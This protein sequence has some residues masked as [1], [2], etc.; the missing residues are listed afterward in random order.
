MTLPHIIIT[1]KN[2]VIM[3]KFI[4]L[5]ALIIAA[6]LHLNADDAEKYHQFASEVRNEVW[7]MD[8]PEFKVTDIPE[9]YRNESAVIIAAYRGINAKKKSGIAFN[10][11]MLANI[12][13]SPI[14]TTA[15]I[16]SSDLYRT[17][18][19]INDRASL[20]KFSEFDLSTKEKTSNALNFWANYKE[21][22][23]HV[24]G[25]RIIKPDGRVIEVDTDEFV[26]VKEGKN[27]K[28]TRQKLAVPGLEIGDRIDVFY[29]TATKL[30][31]V[32]LDPILIYFRDEYPIMN[33]T[34]RCELDDD[35]STQIRTMNGAPEFIMSQAENKDYIIEA[36]TTGVI[37]KEPQIWYNRRAQSPSAF[38]AIYNRRNKQD[39]TPKSAKKD[40]MQLNPDAVSIQNDAWEMSKNVGYSQSFYGALTGHLDGG[41]KT[42]GQLK[43][44]LKNGE[45]TE[46]Q[47]ADYLANLMAFCYMTNQYKLY[48]N[49][50]ALYLR[51]FMNMLSL[52][53][54]LVMTTRESFEPIDKAI[55]YDNIDWI[56]E[57]PS[58]G[59]YYFPCRSFDAPGEIPGRYQ[60][61]TVARR[62][63]KGKK[64]NKSGIMS[65]TFSMPITTPEQN[66]SVS[67]IAASINGTALDISRREENHGVAKARSLSLLSE[68]DIVNG[69][70]SYLNRY[71]MTITFKEKGKKADEREERY[72]DG[73][74]QQFKDIMEEIKSYHN[75]DAAE[76]KSYSID[77]IGIDP[78]SSSM[79]YKI[80]Y[81]MNG[82]VKKAGKNII[83]SVGNLIGSQVEIPPPGTYA[84]RLCVYVCAARIPHTHSHRHPHRLP[85]VGKD[86]ERAERKHLKFYRIVFCRRI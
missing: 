78:D 36:K 54:D 55:Y 33:Y 64:N 32:H 20:E 31:N 68:E 26:N 56:V 34:V 81:V 75:T 43:K 41:K 57:L 86:N 59:R 63:E 84:H 38:I 66:L 73:R 15:Q 45:I 69:Y 44:L 18:I 28:E 24:L 7:N 29:Y 74:E 4:L 21:D 13:S 23:Q 10:T 71:G 61:R 82:I 22:R 77:N 46:T 50:A 83:I 1:Y 35:L 6:T 9:K 2:C 67:D 27:E 16:H 47:A 11:A 42:Y 80:D 58:A 60:G 40:G 79:T 25:V 5:S 12:L 30:K 48:Y 85:R 19:Q 8:L 3:K 70:L 51:N 52:K 49:D 62:P 53:S 39:F 17:L 72:R 37:E 76:V 14:R 65:R